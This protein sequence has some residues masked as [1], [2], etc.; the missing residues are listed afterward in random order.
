MTKDNVTTMPGIPA[1]SFGEPNQPLIKV[2]KRLL[3]LAESGRL[4]RFAGVGTT[5][6]DE[7]VTGVA[8][9]PIR[10]SN[11]YT[12]LGALEKLKLD[13]ATMVDTEE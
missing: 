1:P 10:T 12:M 9:K 5:D 11:V 3:E 6:S 2:L 4:Q 7:V 8:V 13:Y